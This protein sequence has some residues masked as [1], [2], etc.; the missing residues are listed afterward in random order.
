MLDIRFGDGVYTYGYM[1]V[2]VTRAGGG[3]GVYRHII[4]ANHMQISSFVMTS[5]AVYS[6][7]AK[8]SDPT[9]ESEIHGSLYNTATTFRFVSFRSIH[10]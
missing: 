6:Q 5:V 8:F 9:Q 3:G 4:E 7:R 1:C 2:C 10:I